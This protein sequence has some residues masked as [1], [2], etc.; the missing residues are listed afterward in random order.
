MTIRLPAAVL[1]LLVALLSALPAS[2]QSVAFT[3]DDGPSLDATPRLSPAERNAAILAALARHNVRAALLLTAGNGA[4]RPEGLALARAWGEAGHAIGNHTMTHP[5]LDKVPLPAYQQELLDCDRI[6]APLPGYVKWFRFTYLREGGTPEKRDGMR[7]FLRTHGY[8]NA[9][10]TL[11]TSDWRLDGKL[12]EVLG[13]NPQ[14][15]VAPIRAAYLAHVRQRALAYRALAHTVQGRDIP[16]VI[17][18]HHNLINALWL[19]DVI[20]QFKEMGWTITTPQA[21]YA[22]PVYQLMPERP[23]A[24]QS[25]LLSMARSLGVGKFDGWER[26]VDD[27][28]YEIEALRRQGL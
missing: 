17:L 11:D 3:F 26:L 22:D 10:V 23:V 7:A 8:R 20:A 18:L 19:D 21:A 12:A 2:A 5:D 4:N 9:Y 6:I 13:K 16:Q 28:D 24:G 25:L 15:D 27:A 1:A 14:A